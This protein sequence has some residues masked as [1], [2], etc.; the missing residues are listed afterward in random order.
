MQRY[1]VQPESPHDQ[2]ASPEGRIV[3]P[4]RPPFC[5]TDESGGHIPGWVSEEHDEQPFFQTADPSLCPGQVRSAV[6]A[7]DGRLG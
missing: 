5:G 1:L 2:P 6:A 4:P 7:R 3:R